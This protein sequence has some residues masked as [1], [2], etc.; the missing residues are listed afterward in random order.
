MGRK[1]ISIFE[2]LEAMSRS[3]QWDLIMDKISDGEHVEDKVSYSQFE[4]FLIGREITTSPRRC[5]EIWGYIQR[6]KLGRR[7]N[8]SDALL[9]D[10]GAVGEFLQ[11][12]GK[13]EL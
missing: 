7:I 3:R 2:V 10:I 9:I 13:V 11:M 4:D 8:Q 5:R 1:M 12:R 6:R